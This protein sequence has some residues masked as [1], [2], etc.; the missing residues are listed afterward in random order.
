M[1]NSE[2][3]K[4][5]Q[6]DG[7]DE[8]ERIKKKVSNMKEYDNVCLI[9][10]EVP[11]GRTLKIKQLFI[12]IADSWA[13]EIQKERL[14]YKP[15]PDEPARKVNNGG[16]Y[17]KCKIQRENDE[18]KIELTACKYE[19]ERRKKEMEDFGIYLTSTKKGC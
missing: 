13:N 8:I 14:K 5:I 4:G 16:D 17:S 7:V 12:D 18:L 19:C 1:D 10:R 11:F 9:L 15:L 3:K 2:K 6:D